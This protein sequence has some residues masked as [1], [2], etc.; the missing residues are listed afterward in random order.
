MHLVALAEY[1]P[2]G[3]FAQIPHSNNTFD[4]RSPDPYV[5]GRSQ[6]IGSFGPDGA[7]FGFDTYSYDSSDL[8]CHVIGPTTRGAM[9]LGR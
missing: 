2:G 4:S 7:V 8:R 1:W 6:A 5:L 9:S 3:L